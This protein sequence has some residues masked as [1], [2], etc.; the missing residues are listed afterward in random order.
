MK[1]KHKDYYLGLIRRRD[2]LKERL[3]D[4][5]GNPDPTKREL[6]SLNWAIDLVEYLDR[7]GILEEVAR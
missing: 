4:Y 1:P 3:V 7:E 6:A 5:K 2:R